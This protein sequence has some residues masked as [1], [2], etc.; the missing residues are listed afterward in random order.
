MDIR[1]KNVEPRKQVISG[2]V[3]DSLNTNKHKQAIKEEVREDIF[4]VYKYLSGKHCLQNACVTT[5]R[6]QMNASIRRFEKWLRN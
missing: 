5:C 1:T 4:F 3:A 6:T 2:K